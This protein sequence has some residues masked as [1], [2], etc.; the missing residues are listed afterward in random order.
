MKPVLRLDLSGP[1]G[2]VY[3]VVGYAEQLLTG[4]MLEHFQ[5]EIGAATLPR[6][7]KSYKDILAI[8]NSYVTL[9][10]TSGM[11]AEYAEPKP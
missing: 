6:A 1:S 4:M 9:V 10:D 3:F 2:N 7:D 5:E 11:Y 8:V